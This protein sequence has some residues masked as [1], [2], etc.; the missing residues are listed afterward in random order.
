MPSRTILDSGRGEQL[1]MI[2]KQLDAYE[3]RIQVEWAA[4]ERLVVAVSESALVDTELG[5]KPPLLS[6]LLIGRLRNELHCRQSL[7]RARA[8]VRHR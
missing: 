7:Y 5:R 4:V 2:R 8:S 3:E 6:L 1:H